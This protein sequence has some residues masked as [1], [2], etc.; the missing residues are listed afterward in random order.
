M[1]AAPAVA[2]S[3]SR[4]TH[5]GPAAVV[6]IE[7][8]GRGAAGTLFKAHRAGQLLDPDVRCDTSQC[9]IGVRLEGAWNVLAGRAEVAALEKLDVAIV[10]FDEVDDLSATTTGST[11]CRS[12]RSRRRCER[13]QG[14]YGF[15][16]R[17]RTIDTG[18]FEC[19]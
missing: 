16:A 17:T 12:S 8:E 18:V 13:A 19:R 5:W 3:P 4:S 15:G 7:G 14:L 9:E 6:A 1:G 11:S 10:V 2:G